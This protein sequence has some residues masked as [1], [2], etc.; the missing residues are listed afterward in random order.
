MAF[1]VLVETLNLL[2]RRHAARRQVE[3]AGQ[4]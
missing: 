3:G 4:W 2:M 1:S